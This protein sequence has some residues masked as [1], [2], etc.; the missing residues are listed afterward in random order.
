MIAK[1]Y[2]SS[3]ITNPQTQQGKLL[4]LS[5]VFLF[6]L[7][8]V[9]TFAPVAQLKQFQARMLDWDHWI[10][11]FVWLVMF[12][13]LNAKFNREKIRKDIL[14]LP[15]V[16]T[17]SGWGLLIVWRLAPSLGTKQTIWFTLSTIAFTLALPYREKILF[18]LR[19]YKYVWLITGL[20][21]TAFTFIFGT[22]PTNMGPKLWLGCCGIYLQPAEPLKLLLILYLAAYFADRQPFSKK[23][24]PLIL[25]TAFMAGITM[26][27]LIFQRD[28]GT[29]SIFLFIYTSMVYV[30]TGKKRFVAAS[31]L[32]I[33]IGVILGYQLFDVVQ[34]RIDAW[35]N[36]WEDPSGRSYQIVQSLISIAAGGMTGRGPGMGSPNLVPIAFSD[37]IFS[38]IA[39][40]M[41]FPG[42]LGLVL[43]FIIFT[44]RGLSVALRSQNRYHRYLSIGLTTYVASQAIL[45][46]GGNIRLLP[47]TGVTLPFFSYGGSSLVT[48]FLA[49]FLIVAINQSTNKTAT[50][51]SQPK[52]IKHL[53]ALLLAGFISI[54]I[55]NAWW[56]I[57][58]GPELLNRLDN[59]RRAISDQYN[60]RGKIVDRSF[61]PLSFST[62]SPGNFQRVYPYPEFSS[63]IGYTNPFFGQ[64]GLE[65]SLDPVL[66]GLEFQSQWTI[67]YH[68]LL[69]G[70]SPPGLDIRVTLDS[71]LQLTAA[72]HLPQ[73][74]GAV[75][76][77][78]ATNGE[79]LVLYSNPYYDANNL[80]GIWDNL[81]IDP[82]TP[83]INRA[84]QSLYP[85][86]PVLAP[87]LIAQTVSSGSL[88]DE[89]TTLQSTV[90]GTV[91]EC[92]SNVKLPTTWRQAGRAG[93]PAPLEQL[94][95]S[96]GPE[97]LDQL[98]EKLGFYQVPDIRLE[99]TAPFIPTGIRN[100][101]ITAIG[102]RDVLVSPLQM[103][104]SAAALTNDG[105]RPSA[106][107]LMAIKDSQ[108]NWVQYPSST[109]SVR[110]FTPRTA[111]QTAQLLKN[112]TL[113]IWESNAFA[114][115]ENGT[116]LTWYIGGTLPG[117]EPA[118]AVAVLL[119]KQSAELAVQIGQI[120]L[121]RAISSQD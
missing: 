75:A 109:D 11:Y 116:T 73:T 78:N 104:Y 110:V 3:F 82:N 19:K 39:E 64:A 85:P 16:A 12:S 89:I 37:F 99:L 50:I 20:I 28:L 71:D 29:A 97:G 5:A 55:V 69:Y 87:F 32:I 102:Q 95:T 40:E 121:T 101:S 76:L 83:L 31:M 103:A 80:D 25:P 81:Q 42:T 45:I 6:V 63:T 18:E 33:G 112:E 24:I 59:A 65:A 94:G 79:I 13:A 84:T 47:L 117:Q 36:P 66:R 52:T 38:A 108:G 86:G 68:H 30:A 120:L 49:Y 105:N 44:F 118:Y 35:I 17:M 88:P 114:Q 34:I 96:L 119:E 60:E 113:P 93:C 107:L 61:N 1:I 90:A 21:L 43:I 91:F 74:P 70:Q 54:V 53:S 98:F 26:L 100:A 48:S 22:N 9:I 4:R 115:T 46:I 57:Y 10:G 106:H 2:S 67:W 111:N 77:V 15:I 72:K 8:L 23:I 14:L 92:T 7:C 58:R 51:P 41:G 62:G 27:I 56:S